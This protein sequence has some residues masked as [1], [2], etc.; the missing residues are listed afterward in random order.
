MLLSRCARVGSRRNVRHFSGVIPWGM[1]RGAET[2]IVGGGC[3]GQAVAHQLI[4]ADPTQDVYLF[5]PAPI[6]YYQPG[7]TLAGAGLIDPE[8]CRMWMD[9]SCQKFN[10][11]SPTSI[12]EYRPEDNAVVNDEGITIT[13]EKLVVAPGL[14]LDWGAT[15]GLEEA[16]ADPESGVCSNYSYDTMLLTLPAMERTTKG[17]AIFTQPPMP[18]KCPGAPQKAMYL[19]DAHWRDAG[20]RDDID[21]EFVSALPV[22]FGVKK[23][24][25]ALTKI[26]EERDMTTTFNTEL[27]EVDKDRKVAIFQTQDGK[28]I[29]KEYDFLHVTPKQ[30]AV[31]T[32]KGS[33]I[34]DETG[35]VDVDKYT[36]QHKKYP[37][38]YSLGDACNA[39]CSKTAAAIASQ[40]PVVV[41]GIVS[42]FQGVESKKRYNGY[43][44]CP[45]TT[46][47]SR[48]IL[49]EFD[50]DKNPQETFPYNQAEESYFA[51]FLK[52][53]MFL[54]MYF[55]KLIKGQ[56]MGVESL[57]DFVRNL[58]QKGQ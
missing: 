1:K 11:F 48:A 8:D 35:F 10:S 51:Y 6:H 45:L 15:K 58:G 36:L 56:W 21:I 24:S 47:Y 20:V 37:N 12:V 52:R 27:I 53:H 39:P 4:K 3:A 28:T 7:Y 9:M 13:Y 42:A 25:D 50:Y 43:G 46:G 30:C 57:P 33:P 16:L 54:G 32:L 22:L 31:D 2:V 38:I 18:V 55:D 14:K 44:A 34:A 17:K 26:C 40:A 5:E 49:A 23:Y 41:D 19:A 29:E